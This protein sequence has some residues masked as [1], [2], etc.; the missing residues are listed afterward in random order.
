MEL[1]DK[2]DSVLNWKG[3]NIWS[4]APDEWVYNAIAMMSEKQVG[5]LVVLSEGKVTG[6]VSER[7]YAR[8]VILQG[9]SSKHTLVRDIM[10]S[11]VVFVTPDTTV[12]ECMRIMTDRR[13]RHLPVHGIFHV[14]CERER[15]AKMSA[16]VP[17]EKHG[18]RG[19]G[20]NY[21]TE[22]GRSTASYNFV[23]GDV[24][25][26][27]YIASGTNWTPGWYKIA[28]IDRALLGEREGAAVMET[29][30]RQMVTSPVSPEM[31]TPAV[32]VMA[33]VAVT[34]CRPVASLSSALALDRTPVIKTTRQR[35]LP[36]L[37]RERLGSRRFADFCALQSK[38][39]PKPSA[40]G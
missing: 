20:S 34:V 35:F 30:S 7:D 33:P 5:A 27:V 11:P 14:V 31:S 12:D 29:T 6:I 22:R 28:R 25:A 2:I 40:T 37:G 8:K 32:G 9:K 10:S 19:D 4:V 38:A 26:W 16:V 17:P 15:D 39:S 23:A 36:P 1:V 24:G 21:L 3:R 13:L 18:S